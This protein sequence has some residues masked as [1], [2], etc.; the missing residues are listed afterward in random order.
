MFPYPSGNIHMG[1]VRNYVIG[2][3]TARYHKLKG[4]E[5]IHPMGWDAFGLPAENAAIQY[6]THPQDW[7]QT[8]IKNMKSQL[9][10]LDLDLDWDRELA[11]CNED[12]YRHQQELFIDLYHAGLAYKKD[13][14]VNWDP[15]DQTVLANEQVIDGKGWRTG[16]EV[17][18]KNLSQWFFKITHYADELL[19]DIENL[20]L[21]PEKVKTMQRNWIG[22]SVGAEIEFKINNVDQKIKIFTTR[23]DTIYGATFIAL[24]INHQFVNTYLDE[25]DIQKIKKQFNAIEHDKEKIGI[26]LDIDCIN[27]LTNGAIPIYIANF[28]LDNYGEGA[29]FGCPAHDERDYEFAKKYQI[30][31]KKVVMCDDNQL[32]FTGDGVIIN[33][34][35]LNGLNKSRA[36]S[37]IIE[38]FEE[39]NIGNKSVNFKIRDWGVSRQ[40]YWGCPIPVIYYED[41]SYRVLEKDELPVVLP[42]DVSLEGKGNALLRNDDWRK[43]ICPKTNKVAFRETDTLDTFVDSSWYYIRFLN[44]HLDKPFN[45]EDINK[46]LPVDK[47]IGGIEHAILHL[48]YSRFFMKA[49]RD[50]YKLE[51]SEPFKQLFTQGMITHKTYRANN[52]EWVMP[53]DV[54]SVDGKLI[55]R[56]TKE[57]IIEGPSEKMSKSK[58]NVIEPNEILDSYGIDATRIFM[59]SDSPPDRELEWT[60]EGIQSSKNLVNRLERYFNQDKTEISIDTSKV[61]EK[62]ISEMEKNILSF[63]LNKCIA[64][65]YTLINFLEKNRI[66]LKDHEVSK[67]VLICLFPIIPRL[68][69]LLFNKL[70]NDEISNQNWPKINQSL[71]EE[72]EIN[73]PIQIQGKLIST[74]NTKKGYNEKDLLEDIY[75]IEKINNKINGKKI[76]RVI[77]VQD[78]II[79]IIIN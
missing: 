64:N 29:I 37:K 27:P 75:K 28:V 31:I 24:S 4:D 39:N 34:P 32:P 21:W 69:S 71:I 72:N 57:I 53:A 3:I 43:V 12:Y 45:S 18:K 7:T 10:K 77:N 1:H 5:V 47:Y 58:K 46:Y 16:A 33:S 62:F 73:L 19:S 8:N 63:S 65:I 51:V 38:Y 79:N 60:D 55:H 56:K 76:V 15:I 2:D 23:P 61:I 41:G 36:I 17:E 54:A 35:L 66:Y 68:S 26:P 9:Q 49:L 13:A 50:I 11:T 22:K 70:F 67:R 20:N 30:P 25:A 44:N 42:Y 14:L 59:I 40:R 78:K 52:S 6:K 48:L 74:I